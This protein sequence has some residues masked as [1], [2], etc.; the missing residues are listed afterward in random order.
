MVSDDGGSN[1]PLL[2]ACC[3]AVRFFLETEKEKG[4][5]QEDLFSC[6]SFI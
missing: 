4:G 6:P 5:Q 1:Y 3:L 2:T